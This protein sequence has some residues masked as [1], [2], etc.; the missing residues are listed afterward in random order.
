M[1]MVQARSTHPQVFLISYASPV[2]KKMLVFNDLKFYS[3]PPLPWDWQAPMW[4]KVELGILAG[5][6]Y[7][8][9]DE[10]RE[11][12]DFLA[13]G[14][15]DEA[16]LYEEDGLEDEGGASLD[17]SAIVASAA[18]EKEQ[19]ATVSFSKRPLTFLQDWL[20]V[21]RH[22]QDFVHTPMGFLTQ[23]KPLP[24]SHPFFCGAN[25]DGLRPA[26]P[27]PAV[28]ARR[29]RPVIFESDEEDHFDGVDDM[30]ANVESDGEDNEGSLQGDESTGDDEGQAGHGYSS[31]ERSWFSKPDDSDSS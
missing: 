30:G 11:L 24:E 20:A 22:G 21:R 16:M 31:D 17:A 15:G 7:F 28:T 25:T 4:L 1:K 3:M 18:T 5:R 14:T 8:E 9:W 27:V 26:V 13:I 29:S 10:Y 19:P 6:L 12:C 2:T 23:S